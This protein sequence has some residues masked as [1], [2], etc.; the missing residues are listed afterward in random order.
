MPA[1]LP[2]LLLSA[3]L[4]ILPVLWSAALV[5]AAGDPVL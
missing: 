2:F 1:P 3:V 5:W 4:S